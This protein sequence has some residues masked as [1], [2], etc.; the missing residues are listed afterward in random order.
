MSD[1]CSGYT[2]NQLLACIDRYGPDLSAIEIA[3][4]DHVSTKQV[5][6]VVNNAPNAWWML[7]AVTG[8]W[9]GFKYRKRPVLDAKGKA[10]KEVGEYHD[11]GIS[12]RSPKAVYE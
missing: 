7:E 1:A 8:D 12:K 11:Q 2:L 10:I 9:R 4:L 3:H 6:C 5:M